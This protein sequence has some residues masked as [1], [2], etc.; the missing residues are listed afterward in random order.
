M[1]AR[2]IALIV[3]F[4]LVPVAARSDD[5]SAASPAPAATATATDY[6]FIGRSRSQRYCSLET[7]RT[8]GAIVVTLTNDKI[9]AAGIARLRAADLDR[10]DLTLI[11]REKVMRDL[12]S[13]AASIQHNL[14]AGQAELAD[15]RTLSVKEP[16]ATRSPE[17]K[18]LAERLDDAMTRQE[19]VGSDLA[20]MLTI[21]EGRHAQAEG[22]LAAA[23]VVPEP[24]SEHSRNG[25]PSI[26][27]RAAYE[28]LNQLFNEVA[29]DFSERSAA[30]G[31]AEDSAAKHAPKAISG[32]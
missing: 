28:P 6:P 1:F 29:D 9:I 21:V 14:R 23:G 16:D 4:A 10:P 11:D 27:E 15:L 13:V 5:G 19:S 25:L 30:I 8:N 12:R 22:Q 20:K 7:E 18:L 32:C 24:Q 17:L 3:L 31:Q 26:D 2:L